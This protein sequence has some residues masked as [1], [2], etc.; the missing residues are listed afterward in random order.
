M[1]KNGIAV[2]F[3]FVLNFLLIDVGGATENNNTCEKASIRA[4]SEVDAARNY[5]FEQV[6]P[7]AE[8]YDVEIIDKCSSK[9]QKVLSLEDKAEKACAIKGGAIL[10]EIEK[11]R[12]NMM[13][14]IYQMGVLKDMEEGRITK[15]E[16]LLK[17]LVEPDSLLGYIPE[18]SE[19]PGAFEQH[20]MRRY[21]NPLFPKDRRQITQEEI[22]SA[23]ER[24]T[25]DYEEVKSRLDDLLQDIVSLPDSIDFATTNDFLDRL[26]DLTLDAMGV[27]GQ[28][29]DVALLAQE[30]RNEF[31]VTGKKALVE[32]PDLQRLLEKAE[33]FDQL[34]AL[35]F[36]TPFAAQMLRED[37]SIPPSEV[38]PAILMEGPTEIAETIKSIDDPN[39]Q[40][41]FQREAIRLL[42]AA[43][44]EGAHIENLESILKALEVSTN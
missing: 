21:K 43:K 30:L 7:N 44:A 39:I 19:N 32:R 13:K 1:I 23:R 36:H 33:H 8:H 11:S 41:Q 40:I 4:I 10:A 17:L 9:C 20:L 5:C 42:Q 6:D 15:T 35:R 24:D 27:G 2:V 3:F 34:Y 31:L 25:R 28:A 18:W 29:S 38:L 26:Q 12:R 16:G 37:K 14:T 22:M